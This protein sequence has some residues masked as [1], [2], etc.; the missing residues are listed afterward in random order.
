LFLAEDLVE[1]FERALK[2]VGALAAGSAGL[3]TGTLGTLG[4][5]ASGTALALALCAGAIAV[6]ARAIALLARTARSAR[7]RFTRAG[8]PLTAG[9]ALAVALLA[10]ETV[11]LLPREPVARGT[12]AATDPFLTAGEARLATLRALRRGRPLRAL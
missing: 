10:W 4:P 12:R 9:A 11:A 6:G 1:L 3:R 5:V 2:F 8:L 7:A